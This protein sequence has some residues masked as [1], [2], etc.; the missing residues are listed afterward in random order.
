MTLAVF[1]TADFLIR[2]AR[3][4]CPFHIFSN[5]PAS[6][7]GRGFPSNHYVANKSLSSAL[8]N[9]RLGARESWGSVEYTNRYLEQGFHMV[10]LGADSGF[11]GRLARQELKAARQGSDVEK[12]DSESGF[13]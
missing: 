12:V 5:Y 1:K 4:D 10:T 3:K 13:Y 7:F 2:G 11:M 9:P 6:L 8:F